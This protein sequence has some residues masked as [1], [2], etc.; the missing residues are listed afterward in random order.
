MVSRPG[1]DAVVIGAG[2]NGLVAAAHLALAGARVLVVEAA[3]QPGGGLRTEELTLPGFRHDVCAA[4]L[5]LSVA[6]PAM[7]SLP[8][9]EHGVR[10]VHPPVALAHPLDGRPAA[11]LYR[12]LDRTCDAIATAAGDRADA[13]AWEALMRPVVD[14]G[15][16][17]IDG[18]L[19]PLSVPR[20]P[21]ALARFARHGLGGAE[22]LARRR[23]EGS[24]ARAL[25]AGLAA[26]SML[27]LDQRPTAAYA[28]LLGALAHHVGWP[29]A[30]G[31]SS[32]VAR[33]LV[34]IIESNGG[35]IVV[36]E[37]VTDHRQLPTATAVIADVSPPGLLSILG[38]RLPAGYRRRIRRYRFGPGVFKLDWA[39]SDPVPWTDPSVANAATVH[40]GGTLEEIAAV[41][42]EVLAGRHP[43]QPFVLLAQQ[44]LFDDSR[45]PGGAHTLWGYCHVPNG[46][47]VDM[48]AA[49]EAQ[50]ERFA[51][52]F[53]DV[54][55][56]R[57]AMDTSAMAAHG[58]NYIG[59]DINGG[60]GDLRQ[61]IARPVLSA[62]PWRLPVRGW[63]LCSA[64]TPPGGGVHG[65][66]GWQ[67]ARLALARELRR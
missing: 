26:H 4:I 62:R 9:E 42:A 48:T 56:A 2:P 22:A 23:F 47:T 58:M 24:G 3:E 12:E 53:A 40:L 52:G 29:L 50:I 46:S 49:I 7:R 41:E 20:H 17:V 35:E 6:S 66:G 67:A 15:A 63:Y 8:L 38:D 31:G 5:P 14:A 30:A 54:V 34:S 36:G 55:L 28:V 13:E 39:L 33:A 61:F 37:T 57:H 18:L 59:G 1:Y 43:E 51:P 10:W 32:S 19:N 25:L 16:D 11:L 21:L 64:S 60:S 44:S 45:A 27:R 65:M